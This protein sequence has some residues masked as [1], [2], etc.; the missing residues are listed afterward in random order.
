MAHPLI[1]EMRP[2]NVMVRPLIASTYFHV[3]VVCLEVILVVH[4][5]GAKRARP[6]I[7]PT[8]CSCVLQDF[9]IEN[10]WARFVGAVSG[11]SP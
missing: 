7:A 5:G 2:L 10:E 11:R 1:V 6:L 4:F 3:Q 8:I 9:I